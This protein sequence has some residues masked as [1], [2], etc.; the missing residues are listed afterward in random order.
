M[1]SL[2]TISSSIFTLSNHVW[3]GYQVWFNAAEDGSP[4][5]QWVHWS[6]NEVPKAGHVTFEAYPDI[7]DY[8]SDVLYP[9]E[10]GAIPVEPPLFVDI[11]GQS[12]GESLNKTKSTTGSNRN[13]VTTVI[14][15]EAST[16]FSSYSSE[17]IDLHFQ[18]MKQYHI[19]GVGIQ[20]F[21]NGQG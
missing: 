18:W 21:N 9:T 20:R 19:D 4:L 2:D 1:F 11:Q 14:S 5:N 16:L 13:I 6:A 10:L 8:N 17:A 3:A 15:E 12:K 7:H